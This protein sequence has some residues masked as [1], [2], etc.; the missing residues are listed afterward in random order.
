MFNIDWHGMLKI[1]YDNGWMNYD[2]LKKFVGWGEL[3]KDQFADITGK[4]YDSGQAV[5]TPTQ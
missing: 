5:Q 1:E 3:T 4:D 2:N